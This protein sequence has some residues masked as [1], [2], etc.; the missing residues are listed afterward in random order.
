MN[1]KLNS[2]ED[3]S[4][5]ALFGSSFV[6]SFWQSLHKQFKPFNHPYLIELAPSCYPFLLYIRNIESSRLSLRKWY[7]SRNRP[8]KQ[9]YYKA[10]II[11]AYRGRWEPLLT[12]LSC[13]LYNLW[14][15]I[16]E[17]L[18]K[19]ECS[20]TIYMNPSLESTYRINVS[21]KFSSVSVRNCFSKRRFGLPDH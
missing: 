3:H 10:D 19:I 16:D 1:R 15:V 18:F 13:L 20:R 14:D 11:R 12:M 21:W 8:G 9:G 2:S 17:S 5:I 6:I 7:G 4:E